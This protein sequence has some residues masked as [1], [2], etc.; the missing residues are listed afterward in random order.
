MK[1]PKKLVNRDI[2]IV[3]Q[4]KSNKINLLINNTKVIVWLS[5]KVNNI[6]THQEHLKD[7]EP[8]LYPSIHNMS[9]QKNIYN[10][11]RECKNQE[12]YDQ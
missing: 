5:M 1:N 6:S 9:Q 10:T 8:S 2:V 11:L 7:S 3:H 12:K 4:A